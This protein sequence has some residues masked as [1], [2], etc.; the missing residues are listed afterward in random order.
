MT[1][2]QPKLLEL[3]TPGL[4]DRE[5]PIIMRPVGIMV[6]SEETE[7]AYYGPNLTGG[8]YGPNLLP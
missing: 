8:A 4:P 3:A 7:G 6:S 2:L 1:K 5:H